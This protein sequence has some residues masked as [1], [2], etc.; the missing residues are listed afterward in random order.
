MMRN[1]YKIIINILLLISMKL[2][3]SF[4]PAISWD[5]VRHNLFIS[6]AIVK[7]GWDDEM[8]RME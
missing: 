4:P 8:R 6:W 5:G 1:D 7:D 2:S 3:F